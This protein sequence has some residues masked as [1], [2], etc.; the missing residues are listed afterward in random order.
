V[1][2]GKGLSVGVSLPVFAKLH[3]QAGFEVLNILFF[4]M[5]NILPLGKTWSFTS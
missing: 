5:L 4:A 2:A 1:L 3:R